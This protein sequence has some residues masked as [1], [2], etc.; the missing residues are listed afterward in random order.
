[1][2]IWLSFRVSV[3]DGDVLF[4]YIATLAQSQ[5]NSLGTGGLTNC[6]ARR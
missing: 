2:S 4:F 5:P 6:I 3:F 1:V